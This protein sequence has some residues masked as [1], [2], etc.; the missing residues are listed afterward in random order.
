[1][2]KAVFL[3]FIFLGTRLIFT[4][5]S[6][7]YFIG[8]DYNYYSTLIS[9]SSLFVAITGLELYN[10]SQSNSL[11]INHYLNLRLSQY[12][13]SFIVAFF[14]FFIMLENTEVKYWVLIYFISDWLLLET[15]RYSNY[16]G[17]LILSQFINLLV[18]GIIPLTVLLIVYLLN[19]TL[20]SFFIITGLI[21][22]IT[23]T[24]FNRDIKFL[25]DFKF[26]FSSKIIGTIPFLSYVIVYRYFDVLMRDEINNLQALDVIFQNYIHLVL[27]LFLMIEGFYGQ[28]WMQKIH[29]KIMQEK[30][31]INFSQSLLVL[32]L[33]VLITAYFLNYNQLILF[34]FAS[35]SFILFRTINSLFMTSIYKRMGLKIFFVFAIIDI[36]I[37]CLIFVLK[38]SIIK[39]S[40]LLF[41]NFLIKSLY[42]KNFFKRTNN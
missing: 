22:F 28:L 27:T 11:D 3:R 21:S 9:Y 24:Y 32:I 29:N 20:S 14:V 6:F 36:A 2:Y 34:I 38:I 10:F 16:K 40:I 41:F 39:I 19:Y 37:V 7:K 31:R 23:L 1:M 12:L 8:D 26:F 5:F 17:N 13:I 33:L 42:E 15:I 30:K 25:F 18:R 35:L 4:F